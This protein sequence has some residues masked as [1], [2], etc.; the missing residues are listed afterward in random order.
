MVKFLIMKGIANTGIQKSQHY[1][2][3]YLI[4]MILRGIQF[5]DILAQHKATVKAYKSTPSASLENK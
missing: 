1:S 3:H 2:W 5:L 4:L